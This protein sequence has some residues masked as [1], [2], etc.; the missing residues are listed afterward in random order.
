[1]ETTRQQAFFDAF[2]ERSSLPVV[3]CCHLSTITRPALRRIRAAGV[4]LRHE[5]D[6]GHER[7]DGDQAEPLEVGLPKWAGSQPAIVGLKAAP[8]PIAVPMIP[9]ARA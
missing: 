9:C 7:D 5:D 8:T 4:R 3:A 1:M 6:R 2:Y